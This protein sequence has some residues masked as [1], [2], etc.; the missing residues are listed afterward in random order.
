VWGTRR[1][2]PRLN[3]AKGGARH[4]AKLTY[5]QPALT[6]R[7][8]PERSRTRTCRSSP[9]SRAS[10]DSRL[11]CCARMRSGWRSAALRCGLREP[12]CASSV[13]TSTAREEEHGVVRARVS[14]KLP[15]QSV[16]TPQAARRWAHPPCGHFKIQS[17]SCLGLLSMW[18]LSTGGFGG[19]RERER[20][21]CL[22]TS[23]TT[24]L[25]P[26]SHTSQLSAPRAARGR[27]P[28]VGAPRALGSECAG[29]G[30]T[31]VLHARMMHA[32]AVPEH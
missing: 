29:G 3:L 12:L 23:R 5:A 25:V 20:G 30:G 9:N 28:R 19:E 6:S 4:E 24:R 2:P 11:A 15:V 14:F 26:S 32:A 7:L 8:K 31:F 17:C 10:C 1:Q 18:R 21:T 16:A 13:K 22:L 27:Q